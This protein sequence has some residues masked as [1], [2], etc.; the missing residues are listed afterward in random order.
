MADDIEYRPRGSMCMSC[1]RKNDDCSALPF[2]S[3]RVIATDGLSRIVRCD[4]FDRDEAADA[5]KL[6][7]EPDHL[8]R[9]NR[10]LVGAWRKGVAARMKGL[11]LS[12]C[13]YKDTRKTDGRLTFSRAFQKSWGDGWLWADKNLRS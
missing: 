9:T 10:A 6:P 13:P 12:A 2:R 1:R 5:P 3:M 7:P 8:D 4:S 11:G